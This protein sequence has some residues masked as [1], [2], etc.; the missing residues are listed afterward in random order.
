MAAV[1]AAAAVAAVAVFGTH[2]WTVANP[3]LSELHEN[4]KQQASSHELLFAG[5]VML[6]RGVKWSVLNNGEGDWRFPFAEIASTTRAADIAFANLEGPIASS[7]TGYHAGST[8]SFRM[9][10]Q[11]IRGLRHAGF[12]VVS[13]ANN[14]MLDYGRPALRETLQRLQRSGIMYVGAGTSTNTT[15]RHKNVTLSDGTDVAFLALTNLGPPSWAA[16]TT[17]AGMA[18]ISDAAEIIPHIE[19]ASGAADVV[20]V[21]F[22]TGTE[23]AEKPNAVQRS[24]YRTAVEA[25]ADLV[26]GHHPHVVQPLEQYKDGWIAY[27]LGNFVFDQDFSEE[28]MRSVLLRA[29]VR[30]GSI[31]NVTT[32]PVTLNSFFQPGI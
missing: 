13:V 28:T 22:H 12:D 2:T 19:N 14:H 11:S 24:L 18:W 29:M 5:D 27:S 4:T 17:T 8:Y 23:Y 9:D 15:Y 31:T 32:T 21:S 7:T 25:G 6:D 26:V 1:F 3:D 20:I 16:G 10:P 30:D